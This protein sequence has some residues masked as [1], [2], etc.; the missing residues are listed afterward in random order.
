[1][2]GTAGQNS[3][4]CRRPL[5]GVHQADRDAARLIGVA[6]PFKQQAGFVG[7]DVAGASV[8]RVVDSSSSKRRLAAAD[9]G[10]EQRPIYRVN[11]VR[12]FWLMTRVRPGVLAH[13][14]QTSG[15]VP[16]PAALCPAC[17]GAEWG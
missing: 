13:A 11:V 3:H 15:G 6:V 9:V 2:A 8:D 7:P 14:R 12:Q 5:V 16:P 10:V 17:G 1:M 4:A